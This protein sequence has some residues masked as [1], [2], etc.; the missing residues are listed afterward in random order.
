MIASMLS[1]VVNKIMQRQRRIILSSNSVVRAHR[2]AFL[3]SPDSKNVLCILDSFSS[4]VT[5]LFDKEISYTRA[6]VYIKSF[7]WRRHETLQRVKQ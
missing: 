6:E 7:L 1:A 2:S 3:G 5:A 4:R